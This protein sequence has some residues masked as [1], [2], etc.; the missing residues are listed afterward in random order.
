MSNP[1]YYDKLNP[2]HF[3]ARKDAPND[4]GI[5]PEVIIPSQ[6]EIRLLGNRHK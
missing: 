6:G 4:I 1:T 5:E 2:L 3:R